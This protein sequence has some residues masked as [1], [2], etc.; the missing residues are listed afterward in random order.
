M[1]ID[2]ASVAGSTAPQ[3][4]SG[5]SA[6]MPAS[7]KMSG[8]FDQIDSSGSGSISQA[9]F[10][11]AFQALDPPKD[12]KVAGAS[13]VW[14]Q[15]DPGNSGSVSRQ[16]FVSGMTAIMRQL[17]TGNGGS[18]SPPSSIPSPLQTIAASAA[19]LQTTI[20]NGQQLDIT[21]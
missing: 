4:W 13:A 3:I 15:L 9:Q 7:Q 14:S 1:S 2:I 21:A 6:R 16:D 18:G 11:Q 8:L 19:A 5:A 20:A 17:R 12:F 10:S